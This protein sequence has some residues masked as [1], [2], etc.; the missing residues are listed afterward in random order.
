MNGHDCEPSSDCHSTWQ[1][2]PNAHESIRLHE[3]VKEEALVQVLEQIVQAPANALNS[4]AESHLVL[5]P[6]ANC[7]QRNCIDMVGHE[8]AMRACSVAQSLGRHALD[9]G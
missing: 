7:R 4:P 8:D 6:L 5:P 9:Q 2:G 3:Q 1:V